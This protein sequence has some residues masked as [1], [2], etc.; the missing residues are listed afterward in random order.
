MFV[1]S[2][3]DGEWQ[4]Y[5][6]KLSPVKRWTRNFAPWPSCR[7]WLGGLLSGNVKLSIDGC[8][9]WV[10]VRCQARLL[11]GGHS[12]IWNAVLLRTFSPWSLPKHA[13]TLG[14]DEMIYPLDHPRVAS[15]LIVPAPFGSVYSMVIRRFHADIHPDSWFFGTA[16]SQ[17]LNDLNPRKTDVACFFIRPIHILAPPGTG[18]L[19]EIPRVSPI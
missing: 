11:E 19:T 3:R 18:W 7:T 1:L 8:Y 12:Q 15:A 16:M 2:L 10:I 6:P 4:R 13:A 9:K 17:Y 14:V 5:H